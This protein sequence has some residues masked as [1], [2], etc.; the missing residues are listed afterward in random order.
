MNCLAVTMLF[1]R[2]DIIVLKTKSACKERHAR[3]RTICESIRDVEQ[4]SRIKARGAQHRI[5]IKLRLSSSSLKV[6]LALQSRWKM[7]VAQIAA[8]SSRQ[9]GQWY[10][11]EIWNVV[12]VIQWQWVRCAMKFVSKFP[13]NALT[14][15]SS[16]KVASVFRSASNGPRPAPFSKA[17]KC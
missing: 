5:K 9:R 17:A 3:R 13:L 12:R 8:I 4:E 16:A 1:R 11:A 15:T 6:F 7:M 2:T 10:M 14:R